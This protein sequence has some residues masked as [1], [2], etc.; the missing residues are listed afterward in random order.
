MDKC[1]IM[2]STAVDGF[3]TL[4]T[5]QRNAK[6]TFNCPTVMKLYNSRMGETDLLDQRVA[7]FRLDRKSRCYF[8]L[9]IFFDLWD[10]AC[11]NAF[12]FSTYCTQGKSL[13]Y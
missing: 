13:C 1:A 11:T 9:R 10:I 7:A 3:Y 6:S 5:V 4:A 2:L 12:L 8:Y